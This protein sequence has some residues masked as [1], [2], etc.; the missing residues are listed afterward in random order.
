MVDGIE[1]ATKG[2]ANVIR[3]EIQTADGQR[4]AARYGI[5][6]TPSYVVFDRA[7][8]DVQRLRTVLPETADLLR[9]LAGS[10]WRGTG[11]I[12]GG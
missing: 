2:L 1:A 11:T 3:A 8:R 10:S 12:E 9:A 4:I 5:E 7:G 6:L